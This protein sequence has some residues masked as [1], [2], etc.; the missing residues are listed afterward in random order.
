MSIAN[1]NTA[2][3]QLVSQQTVEK[4]PAALSAAGIES[5]QAI[6]DVQ[7]KAAEAAASRPTVKEI[8]ESADK[9]SEYISVVSRSLSISVDRDLQEPI[10]TVLDAQTDKVIRQIPSE[11]LVAIAKFLRQQEASSAPTAEALTGVLL[12][13]LS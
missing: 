6:A 1:V 4:T 3:A 5:R 8:Q 10:V 7:E 12:R 11:E 2:T 9:L 13:E